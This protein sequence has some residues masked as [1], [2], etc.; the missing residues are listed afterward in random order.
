MVTLL[1]NQKAM[2]EDEYAKELENLKS[3]ISK[4]VEDKGFNLK[5]NEV[6]I[7]VE[8][9]YIHEYAGVS[10]VPDHDAPMKL[11]YGKEHVHETLFN[12][13]YFPIIFSAF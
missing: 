10:N 8:S 13:K 9:F 6:E 5:V 12:L 3:A 4:A 7:Q 1:L 11:L 2:P